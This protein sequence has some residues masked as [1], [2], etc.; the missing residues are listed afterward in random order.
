MHILLT[1]KCATLIIKSIHN[2]SCKLIGHSLTTA[3]TCKKD[4]ILH[5]NTLLTIWTNLSRNLEG[6]TT[7]TTAL[8]L[9]LRSN[10]IKCLL[11]DFKSRLF[12]VRHLS[13][14]D[15]KCIVENLIRCILLSIIHQMINELRDLLVI[16]DW[17]WKDHSL[18]WFCFS[19]F[20]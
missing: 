15:I 12:L 11:P 9:Y 19:H 17:I 7:D 14:Y 3:L 18:L 8:Y 13:L 4:K 16:E 10:V 6:C 2:L 20:K 1:L 5:R